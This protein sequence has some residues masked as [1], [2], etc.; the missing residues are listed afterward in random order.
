MVSTG[1]MLSIRKNGKNAELNATSAAQKARENMPD[2]DAGIRT[3]MVLS[4]CDDVSGMRFDKTNARCHSCGG[5]LEVHYCE[6]RV[7][8][9][10]CRDCETV[11]MV[12]AHNPKA[13]AERVGYVPSAR[14]EG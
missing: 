5:P 9:L 4:L 12:M 14:K 8:V 1:D 7:Y 10:R 6:S 2:F 11:T 13:A 3:A